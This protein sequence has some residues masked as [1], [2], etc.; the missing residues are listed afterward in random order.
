MRRQW[1][2]KTRTE[3]VAHEDWVFQW[4]N[5]QMR[6]K[7][8]VNDWYRD[9]HEL[10]N[11][12]KEVCYEACVNSELEHAQQEHQTAQQKLCRVLYEKV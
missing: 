12:C 8:I 2:G 6:R 3:L 7:A 9:R 4:R 1:P 5:Y 11:K 10:L